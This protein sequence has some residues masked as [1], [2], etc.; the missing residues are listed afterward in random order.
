MFRYAALLAA[1]ALSVALPASAQSEE[2]AALSNYTLAI[3]LCLQNFRNPDAMLPAFSDAGF[4]IEPSLDPGVYDAEAPGIV[5]FLRPDPAGSYCGVNS[6]LVPF[7]SSIGA[8]HMVTDQ[9]FPSNS[10]SAGHPFNQQ[11]ECPIRTIYTDGT[12]IMLTFQDD[13]NAGTCF[14]DGGSSVTIQAM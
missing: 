8:G 11:P 4:T 5:A 14:G 3:A 10:I 12:I 2:E 7:D 1:M 6:W 9:L 13:G